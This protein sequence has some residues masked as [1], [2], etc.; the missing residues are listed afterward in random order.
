M[1]EICDL[2]KVLSNPL[3]LE[4]LAHIY[5]SKDGLNFG[6]IA[7]KMHRSKLCASGV[8]QYLRELVRLGIVRRCREGINVNYYA[9]LS[10]ATKPIAEI[11][12]L[13]IAQMKKSENRD[14]AGIFPVLMNPFRANVVRMLA[15]KGSLTA[16]TICIKTN[17]HLQ[18]HLRRDLRLALEIG[19]ISSD[20]DDDMPYASYRYNPPKNPII[21][22][23][24]ELLTKA[25]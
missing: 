19:I 4:L 5:Q 6:Y 2:C 16:E 7:D 18:C 14:F 12:A 8:S 13:I 21:S 25:H 22:R 23:M 9:D 15:Q 1:F 17:H 11:V 24:M 20:E 10:H 3:R